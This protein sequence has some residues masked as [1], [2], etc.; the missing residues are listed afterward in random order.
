MC[1]RPLEDDRTTCREDRCSAIHETSFVKI[2]GPSYMRNMSTN[3]DGR[4]L[5]DLV[6][7]SLSVYAT[8]GCTDVNEQSCAGLEAHQL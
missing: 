3:L 2:V 6:S 5:F 7:I 4:N 1:P 8:D